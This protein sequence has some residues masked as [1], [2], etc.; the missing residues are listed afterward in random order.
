MAER[1]A[2]AHRTA[3][4]FAIPDDGK[5]I[6][7]GR[8]VD[9]PKLHEAQQRVV[10][11][12]RRFNVV[13][14]GRRWGKT[15][16]AVD[17]LA[18]PA[19]AGFPVAYF[20]PT[21]KMLTEVW[22]EVRRALQPVTERVS[23][24]EHRLELKGG[25]VVD[26]WSLDNPDAVRGRK[27]KR[28]AIDEAAM[29]AALQEAWQ[30]VIAPTL[31]DYEGDAWFFSTPKGM[32][33]FNTLFNLGQ[34]PEH[35]DWMSW[36]MPTVA[37]PLINP[38]EVERWR[39]ELPEAIFNQEYRAEFLQHEG[40]VFRNIDANLTAKPTTPEQHRGH[41][42]VAGVDWA[43][44]NDFTVISVGCATCQREVALDRFNK[45]GWAVQRERLVSLYRRWKMTTI[46]AEQNSIGEPNIEALQDEGL[47]VRG[48]ETTASSKGPLIQSLALSFERVEFVFLPDPVGKTELVAY[49]ARRSD[50]TG[51]ISYGAPEGM[52]DDIVI[53]RAL[54]RRAAEPPVIQQPMISHSTSVF[55]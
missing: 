40:A 4:A 54:M 34:D 24:Q 17:R 47:P 2:V 50:Q 3:R 11:E 28:A 1:V 18:G 39:L 10:D 31:T 9:L 8:K 49:E 7:G 21:Y 22:R 20:A 46:L 29:V 52:H 48:F 55:R 5:S 25:G 37:N 19:L 42:I 43:R 16:L 36:H 33:F 23:A 45:I 51:R 26:M 6:V 13:A 53:A 41:R 35:P 12:S 27:Y 14:C 32:N 38:K 30:A 15:T 44:V